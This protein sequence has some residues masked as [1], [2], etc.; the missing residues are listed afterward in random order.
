MHPGTIAAAC[1]AVTGD[2]GATTPVGLGVGVAPV[3]SAE[4]RQAGPVT[5]AAA[6]VPAGGQGHRRAGG[7]GAGVHQA[8]EGGADVLLVGHRVPSR[9]ST[10]RRVA[11]PRDV[12]LF[13]VPSLM[14]SAAAVSRTSRSHQ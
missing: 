10:V 5:A 3:G 1:S 11:R 7:R 6:G 4:L 12:A 2:S 8:G 9:S 14:P 13:T